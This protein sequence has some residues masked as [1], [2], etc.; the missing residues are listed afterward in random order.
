MSRIEAT[1]RRCRQEGRI[2]LAAYLTAGYPTVADTLPLV[3]ALVEGGFD[4]V[5]LGVPF[6][7]PLADGATI[8]RAS[9]QALANGITVARCLELAAALRQAVPAPLILMGYFN[10][11]FRYGLGRLAADA[12]AAGVAGFIVPDLAPEEADEMAAAL[13]GRGI[14]RVGLVAPTSSAGRIAKVAGQASGFVYCVALAGVTGARREVSAELAPFLSLVRRHTTLPL[15]VG[16]GLSRPEHMAAVAR[17]ADGAVVGSAI[18]DLID[19]VA[20][21]ERA[22]ALRR[23][24]ASLRAASPL[25]EA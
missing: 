4:L 14:D 12:S 20:P 11:F 8:Q 15:A 1:F 2:A 21:G 25:A 10:P 19:S 24:A 23:F 9:Q 6:S 18:I 17:I 22:A 7:D 13:A 5:E 3:E 16:F